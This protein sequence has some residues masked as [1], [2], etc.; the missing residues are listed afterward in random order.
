MT[1]QVFIP[2]PDLPPPPG[3][4]GIIRWLK[5]NFF[6]DTFSSVLTLLGL[7]LIF[8]ITGPL[9]SWFILDAVFVGDSAD[10]NVVGT[11]AIHSHRQTANRKLESEPPSTGPWPVSGSS[12]WP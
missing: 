1:I 7:Y 5:T 4:A 6:K 10:C 12:A 8:K 11:P 9:L 3:Q 2:A